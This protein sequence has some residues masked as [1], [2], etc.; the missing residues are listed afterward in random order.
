[1]RSRCIS[2]AHVRHGP[3]AALERR[4]WSRRVPDVVP[5]APLEFFGRAQ[6]WGDRDDDDDEGN[7]LCIDVSAVDWIVEHWPVEAVG[8][9]TRFFAQGMGQGLLVQF[10]LAA[11][12]ESPFLGEFLRQ[13]YEQAA[14]HRLH[15]RMPR[16]GY[17]DYYAL[18]RNTIDRLMHIFDMIDEDALEDAQYGSDVELHTFLRFLTNTRRGGSFYLGIFPDADR[19]RGNAAFFPYLARDVLL[20]I[21]D[22]LAIHGIVMHCD[23]IKREEALQYPE[24]YELPCVVHALR[25]TAALSEGELLRLQ[26]KILTPSVSFIK[27][28]LLCEKSWSIILYRERPGVDQSFRTSVH[29]TPQPHTCERGCSVVDTL[30]KMRTM[31]YHAG[32]MQCPICAHRYL[33]IGAIV[34]HY[35][36]MRSYGLNI[37]NFALTHLINHGKP[38]INGNP[39]WNEVHNLRNHRDPNARLNSFQAIRLLLSHKDE[40]FRPHLNSRPMQWTQAHRH[41]GNVDTLGLV[42]FLEPRQEARPIRCGQPSQYAHRVKGRAVPETKELVRIYFDFETYVEDTHDRHLVPYMCCVAVVYTDERQTRRRVFTGINCGFRFIN[43]VKFTI[44]ED[45]V[46]IAHNLGFDFAFIHR[47]LEVKQLME[48]GSLLKFGEAEFYSPPARKW[49]IALLRDSYAIIPY[50]L[51]DFPK[52]FALGE[53]RKEI[54]KHEWFTEET[55]VPT[56]VMTW[57]QLANDLTVSQFHEVKENVERERNI[58]E[59]P[60]GFILMD[61]ACFYCRRDVELL[62]QG[63]VTMRSWIL[64]DCSIDVLDT[65]T[66]PWIAD[67]FFRS[68]NVYRG[69]Y[70]FKG[71]LSSFIRESVVGGRVASA[72]GTKQHIVGSLCDFDAVSLYPSAMAEIDTSLGGILLGIPHVLDADAILAFHETNGAEYDGFVVRINVSRVGRRLRFPLLTRLTPGGSR[73]FSNDLINTPLVVDRVQLEDLIEWQQIEYTVLEGI[74]W[75]SGR[76]VGI[77]ESARF[78]FARRLEL[79]REH[80]PAQL[81]YKLLMNSAYGRLI[82][83]PILTTA[84]YFHTIHKA[85]VSALAQA[86]AHA[87]KNFEWMEY[88]RAYDDSYCIV[89]MKLQVYSHWTVGHVGSE[90]LS[91]SKRVMNRVMAFAETLPKPVPIFYQDTDSMHLF[92]ADL[93]RLIVCYRERYGKEIVGTDLGQFHPDFP[94]GFD[95]SE[96]FVVLGKKAYAHVLRSTTHPDRVHH[97]TRL[98]G[99]PGAAVLEMCA[100]LGCTPIELFRQLLDPDD[101]RE[102]NLLAGG[103]IALR[104][105]IPYELVALPRFMRQISFKGPRPEITREVGVDAF[106]SSLLCD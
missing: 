3:P 11:G 101:S 73:T 106:I 50:P 97:M 103:R 104:R 49:C 9:V 86:L 12:A 26:S 7:T 6:Y 94:D 33:I 80:N 23:I 100:S 58:R 42:R 38:P 34:N 67:K 59:S 16:H 53:Q 56:Y 2:L 55:A 64:N 54:I 91:M 105:P 95:H 29:C 22:E 66:L 79:K 21:A 74:Y 76:T 13:I 77:G 90:I 20:P 78:L 89:K 65:C 32:F 48:S 63:Y 27:L 8:A 41:A 68:R 39:G 43:W 71:V 61:Y 96:E 60:G 69:V 84:K 72:N 88:L 75:N 47:F 31:P 85:N 87:S 40:V 102:F 35:F 52:M 46:L 25:N 99:V 81:V 30:T 28:H 24:G 1:M 44:A 36:V 4:N 45:V 18:T 37:T 15:I 51:R 10:R 19:E 57:N 5:D 17:S 93:E 92:R 62:R 82:R 70:A 14:L 98:K 83:R